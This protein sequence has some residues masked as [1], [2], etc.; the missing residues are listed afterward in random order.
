[1]VGEGW[2]GERSQEGSKSQTNQKWL[3]Y[4]IENRNWDR[5]GFRER[6]RA[7]RVG[8]SSNTRDDPREEIVEETDVWDE[9]ESQRGIPEPRLCE[10]GAIVGDRDPN[11]EGD[12]AI[13]RSGELGPREEICG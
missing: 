8:M 5:D 6:M 3:N 11:E 7:G 13:G 2:S 9:Q 10:E 12:C 4:K 1:M